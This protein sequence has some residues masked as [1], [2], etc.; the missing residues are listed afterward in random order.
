MLQSVLQASKPLFIQSLQLRPHA[1]FTA[2]LLMILLQLQGMFSGWRNELYPVT[3]AFDAQ[4]AL[5]LERA[6]AAHF[7]IRAYGVH[8][9]GYVVA[10]DGS[11][12]LWVARRSA[13]KQTWPGKLDHIVAGGQVS[14]GTLM[15]HWNVKLHLNMAVSSCGLPGAARPS[16]HGLES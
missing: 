4:P 9:N 8:V 12:K 3:A 16:R 11:K 14:T 5:L 2:A 1:C 6:A 15:K 13:T 10:A 7:G